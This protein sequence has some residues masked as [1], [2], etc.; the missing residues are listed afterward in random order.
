MEYFKKF[1]VYYASAAF[2][3]FIGFPAIL[4]VWALWGEGLRWRRGV[5]SCELKEGSWPVGG[6][7]DLSTGFLT[8]GFPMWYPKGWYLHNRRAAG[9]QNA[10]PKP[11]G[12]T[13]LGHGQFYA[14]GRRGKD[15]VAAIDV[16]EDHHTLQ[17]EAA[18]IGACFLAHLILIIEMIQGDW[19]TGLV[20]F[21]L[22]WTLAG[23]LFM[24]A[25][26]WLV[27]YLR[28]GR[29]Y[30]DS[31]HEIGAYAV[32]RLYTREKRQLQ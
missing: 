5:L 30:R 27:A 6:P 31:P 12:A 16:H 15:W 28:G 32:G 17:S 7:V 13:T 23:N 22:I 25:G 18:Q 20:L 10:K 9:A 29:F 26:G 2:D 4:I 21:A 8:K 11:W 24:A 1:W 3:L 14:P 19:I